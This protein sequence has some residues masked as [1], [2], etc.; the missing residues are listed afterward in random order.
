[1]FS[2]GPWLTI[3]GVWRWGC[4]MERPVSS[5]LESRCHRL[6]L[7][8]L[9]GAQCERSATSGDLRGA[10]LCT[11]RNCGDGLKQLETSWNKHLS[12]SYGFCYTW[13]PSSPLWLRRGWKIWKSDGPPEV[14]RQ[15]S[16]FVLQQDGTHTCVPWS[17]LRRMSVNGQESYS[18]VCIFLQCNGIYIHDIMVNLY[19]LISNPK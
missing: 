1:M 4:G 6:S 3:L 12:G 18:F 14:C 10:T 17:N 8:H 15:V 5:H 9:H 16:V 2:H 7:C 19:N 13:K 11:G